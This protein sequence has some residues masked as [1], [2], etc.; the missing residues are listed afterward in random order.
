MLFAPDVSE[1]FQVASSIA[2]DTRPA[3]AMGTTVTPTQNNITGST[4]STIIASGSVTSDVYMLDVNINSINISAA[5]RDALVEIGFDPA[6]GTT[7]T[8]L[9]YFVAGPASS[10]VGNTGPGCRVRLLCYIPSG[11]TIGL[12]G[13]VNSATLTAFRCFMTAYGS[14][15]PS[16]MFRPARRLQDIGITTATSAGTAVTS[17]TTSDGTWTS[18]GTLDF[19]TFAWEFGIGVNDAALNSNTTDVDI[20]VGDSGGTNIRTVIRNAPIVMV[21]TETIWKASSLTY[22]RAKAGETVWGRLQTG[23]NAA[24]TG[25]SL[26]VIAMGY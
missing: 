24:S 4:W 5:A 9:A 12:R 11:S 20:G 26:A 21:N 25:L 17:G 23:P 13:S 7:F 2:D 1:L 15:S 22:A 3:A 18:L 19:N 14:P 6:G 16:H 10:Y 8:H